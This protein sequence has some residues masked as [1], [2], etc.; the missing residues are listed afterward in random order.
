MFRFRWK[1]KIKLWL[2][3]TA[4]D[5]FIFWYIFL[6]S[7]DIVFL[8]GGRKQLSYM[9][10]DCHFFHFYPS[11]SVFATLNHVI[12]DLLKNNEKPL[13]Q[14]IIIKRGNWLKGKL[15][16][17]GCTI[18]NGM[19]KLN[20]Q[21]KLVKSQMDLESRYSWVARNHFLAMWNVVKNYW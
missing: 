18:K 9:S 17:V 12:K 14:E 15:N 11:Y 20:M 19:K 10:N 4:L 13:L 3:G 6:L 2:G 5:I 21:G 1:K 16:I 7:R 8:I